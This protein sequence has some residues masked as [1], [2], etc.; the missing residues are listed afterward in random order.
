M[1]VSLKSGDYSIIDSGQVFLF[2][3]NKDLKINIVADDGYEC[4]VV[5]EFLKDD[6]GELQISGEVNGDILTFTCSNFKDNGSGLSVPVSIGEIDGKKVFFIFWS[7]LE[8]NGP[9]KVRSVK[10]TIFSKE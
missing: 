9:V 3:E 8:G 1:Q 7:Y 5:L 2:E 4:S 10:Y 6:S